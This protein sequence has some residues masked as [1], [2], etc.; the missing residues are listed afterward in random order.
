MQRRKFAQSRRH[1]LSS[2]TTFCF[3]AGQASAGKGGILTVHFIE[4]E[5]RERKKETALQHGREMM[6][7]ECVI[8]AVVWCDTS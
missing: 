5:K 8:F 7:G 1:F 3:L 4:F 6:N 2:I